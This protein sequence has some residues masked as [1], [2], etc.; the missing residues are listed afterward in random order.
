MATL[1]SVQSMIIFTLSYEANDGGATDL[2]LNLDGHLS[3][4]IF[5]YKSSCKSVINVCLMLLIVVLLVLSC[6]LVC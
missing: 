6:C 4:M 1:K 3:C 5:I 2:F